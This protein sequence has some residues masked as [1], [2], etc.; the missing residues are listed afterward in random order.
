MKV[1][2]VYIMSDY[3][4]ALFMT[5][6]RV[7]ADCKSREYEDTLGRDSWVVEYDFTNQKSFELECD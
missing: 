5:T 1:Y 7:K 2:V 6:D 4:T 3:A